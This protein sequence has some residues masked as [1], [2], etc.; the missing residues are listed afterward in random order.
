MVLVSE[1]ECQRCWKFWKYSDLRFGNNGTQFLAVVIWL[2]EEHEVAMVP[3][4][5]PFVFFFNFE[6]FLFI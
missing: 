6:L 1:G 4:F 3:A 5:R 2:V